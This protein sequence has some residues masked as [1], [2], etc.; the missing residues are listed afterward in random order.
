M[1]LIVAASLREAALPERLQAVSA[2]VRHLVFDCFGIDEVRRLK[3]ESS[4]KAL[5]EKQHSFVIFARELTVEAQNALLKL[6]EDTPEGLSL[7]LVVPNAA[8]IIPTLRSRFVMVDGGER[9]E[10]AE[11]AKEFLQST[12]ADR[13]A[14]VA[15]KIKQKNNIWLDTLVSQLSQ[16]REVKDA[17][18]KKSL[19]LA[20]RYFR[21]RGASKKQLLEELALSLPVG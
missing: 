21:N 12:Y 7:Y 3:Q 17:G 19:L 15:D 4:V 13:L 5:H 8:I 18:F 14:L 1:R 10:D 6:F 20:D 16:S 11:L 2:D 9:G